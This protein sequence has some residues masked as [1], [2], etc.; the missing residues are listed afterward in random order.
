MFMEVKN[1]IITLFLRTEDRRNVL[2]T[3]KGMQRFF[4]RFSGVFNCFVAYFLVISETHKKEKCCGN[5]ITA[6]LPIF[7][8]KKHS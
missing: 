4:S 3:F 6:R 1:V 8:F 7:S 2:I 5:N